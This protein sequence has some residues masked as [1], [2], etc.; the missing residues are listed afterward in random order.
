MN[1]TQTTCEKSIKD[2]IEAW[3]EKRNAETEGERKKAIALYRGGVI[4]VVAYFIFVLTL[5]IWLKHLPPGVMFG[6]I[7][8]SVVA[9]VCLNRLYIRRV[10][11]ELECAADWLNRYKASRVPDDLLAALADS[12]IPI[13]AKRE[14]ADALAEKGQIPFSFLIPKSADEQLQE[15]A[16]NEAGFQKMAAF[17]S[18]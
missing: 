9:L 5:P 8:F 3:C 15:K 7:G 12:E 18:P 1:Q 2:V 6:L 11:T 10:T 14:I 17:R 16:E 13:S 4:F